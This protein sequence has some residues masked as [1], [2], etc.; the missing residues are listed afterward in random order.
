MAPRRRRRLG[1]SAHRRPRRDPPFDLLERDQRSIRSTRSEAT[2]SSYC[3]RRDCRG[4]R[5]RPAGGVV[6]PGIATPVA[7][8]ITCAGRPR[9]LALRRSETPSLPP[10]GGT[11]DLNRATRHALHEAPFLRNLGLLVLLGTISAALLDYLFKSGAVRT[12]GK[13]PELARYFA[14]F[15][16][17]NQVVTFRRDVPDDAGPSQIRLGGVGHTPRG[18]CRREQAEH[19]CFPRSPCPLWSARLR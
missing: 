19:G 8:G 16:T 11:I 1:L 17:A 13:G 3:G 7:G 15:Y 4:D 10:S 18:G 2:L 6:S 14:L 5:R 9:C 12:M